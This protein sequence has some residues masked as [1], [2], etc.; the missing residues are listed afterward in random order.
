M[1]FA[2][3]WIASGLRHRPSAADSYRPSPLAAIVSVNSTPPACPTAPDAAVSTLN[4][5]YR[6]VVFVTR[7][8]LLELMPMGPQQ[9]TLSQ[10]RSTFPFNDTTSLTPAMKA[11]G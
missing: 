2:G 3:S 7:K 4:C 9:A 6:P 5:G 1:T 8:V 10:V 11:R